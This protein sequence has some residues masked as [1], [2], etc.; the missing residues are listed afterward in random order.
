M[1]FLF[2]VYILLSI[3]AILGAFYLNFTGK[4]QIQAVLLSV[5]FLIISILFGI[6]WFSSTGQ[7]NSTAYGGAWPPSI[8]T[9]P[10]YLSLIKVNGAYTCVDPIGVTQQGMQKWTDSTQT[11]PKYLFDLQLT[12]TGADRVKALCDHCKLKAVT[13]EGV[14]NGSVCLNREPPRPVG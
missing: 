3:M 2:I 8:N 7:I 4:K 12:L 5:G 13:W 1:N 9:C 6:R 11:D 10:D 14:W